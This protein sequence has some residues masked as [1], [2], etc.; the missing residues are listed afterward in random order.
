MQY[1]TAVEPGVD[2]KIGGRRNN[3]TDH[4]PVMQGRVAL[5]VSGIGHKEQ[6]YADRGFEYGFHP[7]GRGIECGDELFR[8]KQHID[9]AEGKNRQ[10][11]IL[12]PL[13][14]GVVFDGT[15]I[16]QGSDR[17]GDLE[18]ENRC[19]YVRYGDEE[20]HNAA[21]VE[22]EDVQPF[23]GE[24]GGRAF[25]VGEPQRLDLFLFRNEVQT[26][27]L[28]VVDRQGKHQE[29]I[30]F[31]IRIPCLI[32][33]FPGLFTGVVNLNQLGDLI[34]FG[35]DADKVGAVAGD[36]ENRLGFLPGGEQLRSRIVIIHR[37]V[38]MNLLDQ[39][40]RGIV[41]DHDIDIAADHNPGV[42][43]LRRKE[44]I[45]ILLGKHP[46]DIDIGQMFAHDRDG[47]GAVVI[48]V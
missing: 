6:K 28:L 8:Q 36:D 24:N 17:I 26:A 30:F 22:M 3:Q 23:K 11:M 43:V 38:G 45:G 21:P 27:F 14:K 4:D 25:P 34:L 48:R 12:C 40:L 47:K 1:G 15:A 37:A 35:D 2:Q 31:H 39:G 18:G 9:R 44:V 29:L 42:F 10:G 33:G 13:G 46:G 32:F 41:V 7:D 19:Q 5:P 16:A 20:N